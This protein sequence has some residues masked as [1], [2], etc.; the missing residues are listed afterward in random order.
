MTYSVGPVEGRLQ[1]LLR[2]CAMFPPK[3]VLFP[4][5]FSERCRDAAR[6]VETF[7]G[8]F[9]AELTLLYVLEPLTYN[10][11]PFGANSLAQNQLKHYLAEELKHFDVTRVTLNGEPASKIA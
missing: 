7:A 11:L 9:Q 1:S 5:D 4:V 6:M 10:D 3:R 2:R 8:H